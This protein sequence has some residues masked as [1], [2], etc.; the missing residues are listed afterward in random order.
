MHSGAGVQTQGTI[1]VPRLWVLIWVDVT[2]QKMKKR[3]ATVL[4]RKVKA[5]RNFSWWGGNAVGFYF[6]CLSALQA[7][8]PLDLSGSLAD[9]WVPGPRA[10]QAL[11]A[12]SLDAWA[13]GQNQYRT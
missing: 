3:A 5:Y 7:R 6:K 11:A 2:I 12:T 8:D 10:P 9:H 13:G 1:E 4:M